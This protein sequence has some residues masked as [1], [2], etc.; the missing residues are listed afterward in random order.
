MGHTN[1]YP[2]E[3]G[4]YSIRDRARRRIS[5]DPCFRKGLTAFPI[6]VAWRES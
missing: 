2:E 3:T 6:S 1:K 5:F 4:T